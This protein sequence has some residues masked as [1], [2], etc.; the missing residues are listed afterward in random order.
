MI[1]KKLTLKVEGGVWSLNGKSE[2]V[3]KISESFYM[4]TGAGD[5]A[6]DIEE[7]SPPKRVRMSEEEEE[8]LK[9]S[10]EIIDES[11]TPTTKDATELMNIHG[12]VFNVCPYSGK[13]LKESKNDTVEEKSPA[14][15]FDPLKSMPIGQ[16]FMGECPVLNTEQKITFDITPECSGESLKCPMTGKIFVPPTNEEID[17]CPFMH[18]QVELIDYEANALKEPKMK[19]K[20][21]I[22]NVEDCRLYCGFFC[23][24][25]SLQPTFDKCENLG[26]KL[27]NQLISAGALEVMKVAQDEI[28]SKC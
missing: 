5:T 11:A 23:H 14:C 25:E 28:H 27:A 19:T 6:D 1:G 9:R 24:K 17:R 26:V 2:I 21:L 7:S 15:P 16:D 8:K 3:D 12:K 22:E 4:E 13:S 20:S 18:K 10:P